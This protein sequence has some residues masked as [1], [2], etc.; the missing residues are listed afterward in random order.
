MVLVME[1]VVK[2]LQKLLLL[3]QVGI[4]SDAVDSPG[5][6]QSTNNLSGFSAIATG[7]RNANNSNCLGFWYIGETTDWWCTPVNN[8]GTNWAREV[9]WFTGDFIRSY[10]DKQFG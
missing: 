9:A 8:D 3:N 6:D 4:T 7:G 10:P 5:N 1:V 2:K